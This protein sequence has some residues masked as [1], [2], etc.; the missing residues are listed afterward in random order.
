MFYIPPPLASCISL[1]NAEG[2]SRR[3]PLPVMGLGVAL[4]LLALPA[5]LARPAAP[6][7]QE[8]PATAV[9][10]LSSAR[11][12]CPPG[13]AS[14]PSGLTVH[15]DPLVKIN[16]TGT[17]LRVNQD[18]P[19][20]LLTW[21]S[22]NG[23]SMTLS[24][25]AFSDPE[26]G[27][28]WFNK[29]LVSQNGA[30]VVSVTAQDGWVTTQLDDTVIDAEECRTGGGRTY[31]SASGMQLTCSVPRSDRKS[32][33]LKLDAHGLMLGGT[34]SQHSGLLSPFG[35]IGLLDPGCWCSAESLCHHPNFSVDICR[36]LGFRGVQARDSREEGP[37]HPPEPPLRRAA[38]KSERGRGS[39]GACGH[40]ADDPRD[41]ADACASA[42][43]AG[44]P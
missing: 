42:S 21:E 24:G 9:N 35:R 14:V 31:T 15:G 36:R 37:V 43:E 6:N 7:A 18:L 8:L 13:C 28:E 1:P 29:L 2:E 10:M 5:V 12:V 40:P 20:R 4:A 25:Q 27:S 30:L 39:G 22:S 32:I 26:S 23:D 41:G 19:T 34:A 11:I 16:G 17:M 38:R 44:P 33:R 3:G